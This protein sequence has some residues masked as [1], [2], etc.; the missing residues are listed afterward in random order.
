MTGRCCT[1]LVSIQCDKFKTKEPIVFH[2]GLNTIVGDGNNSIGKS[3]L[4]MM[5]DYCFG[6]DDYCNKERNVLSAIGEHDIKFSFNFNGQMKYFIRNSHQKGSVKVCNSNY[7][8]LNVITI[9]AFRAGLLKYYGLENSDLTFRSYVSPYFRI[10]NRE[11]HNELKPLNATVRQA[12]ESGVICILKMYGLYNQVRLANEEY[13]KCVAARDALNNTFRADLAPVAKTDKEVAQLQ[14]E[15]NDLQKELARLKVDNVS[16]TGEVTIMNEAQAQDLREEKKKLEKQRRSLKHQLSDIKFDGEY[17]D[18]DFQTKF[19]K[20]QQ[21]FPDVNLQKIK[22]IEKFHV[23]VTDNLKEEA[24]TSNEKINEMIAII[25]KQIEEILTKLKEIGVG[26]KPSVPEAILDR[27]NQI[28]TLI[29][30]KKKAIENFK[31]LQASK[32]NLNEAK[33]KRDKAVDQL[34]DTI[35]TRINNSLD[36][37]N[38][39]IRPGAEFEPPK[40]KLHSFES[41]SFQI[42]SD[43]GTGSRFKSVCMLDTVLLQQTKLP[44]IAH[45]SIMFANINNETCIDLFKEY[46]KLTNK[47]L[48]VGVDKPWEFD[49]GDNE[50]LAIKYRVIQLSQGEGTLFGTQINKRKIA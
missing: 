33:E 8:V 43:N 26:T 47:Q 36:E 23:A 37:L 50:N 42:S 12:D 30:T 25:D 32:D 35:S 22:D 31:Q 3:T 15:I 38:K 9:D 5:I 41:Y 46:E 11:T 27:Y 45:D 16:D 24:T 7:E 44:A 19:I 39:T 40:I 4:M 18:E 48:F 10:Y 28:C 6:G 49:D 13:L 2:P 20:L 17:Y 21:F 34:F 14:S 1:M 29:D